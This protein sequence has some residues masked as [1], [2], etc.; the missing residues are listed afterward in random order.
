[1]VSPPYPTPLFKVTEA[2]V[3]LLKE[4]DVNELLDMKSTVYCLEKAFREQSEKQ[5]LLPER[6]VIRVTE[7]TIVRTM[8]ASM[9]RLQTLGLKVLL[10][11]PPKRKPG[12]VYFVVMLFD[13]DDASLLAIIAANRLTQLRTGGAS[14]VATKYLARTSFTKAG[15][16]GAGVQGYGQLE[17][18]AN[19][20]NLHE[21][22]VFDIDGDRVKSLAE[23]AKTEFGIIVRQAGKVEDLYEAEV[24][25]TATTSVN[26]LLFGDKLRAGVHVNA[27][28][29]NAPNRQ[30]IHH[31]VLLKSKVFVDREEQVLTEAGDL[32]I[33]IRQGLYKPENILGELADVITGK[34][35]GRA[36]ELDITLFK[37]VGIAL[38]DVAVARAVYD[39]AVSEGKGEDFSF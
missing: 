12:S 25:S 38:E 31:S 6:Q 7:S 39:R 27:I 29:S 9:P 8:A 17:G 21:A 22:V 11:I 23:K 18:L 3:L 30:E 24:L 20:S 19:V 36:S 4:S 37:S 35:K 32:V 15:I 14:A 5:F 2:L 13:Q 10:G 34:I 33:P 28:G 26:P 1:M 16:L